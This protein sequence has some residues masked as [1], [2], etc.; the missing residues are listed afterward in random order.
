METEFSYR[1]YKATPVWDN[2]YEIY[3]GSVD[4]AEPDL[5]SFEGETITKASDD[6]ERAIDCYLKFCSKRLREPVRG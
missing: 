5:I 6:F 1:G 2:D 4:G 3:H